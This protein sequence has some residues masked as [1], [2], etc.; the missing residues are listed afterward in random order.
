MA[1]HRM[2]ISS[3]L[4][5]LSHLIVLT[6]G[7]PVLK[8]PERVTGTWKGDVKI[9]CIYNPLTGYRE[10]L[11]KW[12]VQRGSDHVTIFLR[13]YSGDHVQQAKYRGRLKVSHKVPGDVSLQLNNLQ[14]D[15][16]NHYTCEVTWQTP[17]GDQVRRD[18]ITELRVQKY[19]YKP[20][21]ITTEALTTMQSSLEATTITSS[22]SDWTTS[23]TQTP[24]GT[25]TVPG[26]KLPIFAIILII[27]FCCIVVVTIAFIMF[28]RRTF[29]EYVYEVSRMYARQTSNSEETT[30]VTTIA[31][32]YF[33]NEPDSQALI[34]DYSDDPCLS[35]EYQITTRSTMTIPAC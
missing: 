22:T 3:S 8:T 35:Q 9:Q 17:D 26:G 24:Q 21:K 10:V 19:P 1:S 27:C 11:V 16:R 20:P 14:M 15:D 29:Q 13:D 6:Y 2:E 23:V 7:H 28:R 33:N 12:L 25:T 34:N 30:R 4:L 18:K 31:S 5:F 32:A